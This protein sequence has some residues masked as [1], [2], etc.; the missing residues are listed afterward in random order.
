VTYVSFESVLIGNSLN[1][2]ISLYGLY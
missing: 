2:G 1:S